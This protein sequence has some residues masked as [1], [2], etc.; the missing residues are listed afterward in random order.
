MTRLDDAKK[1]DRE[2]ETERGIEHML[3]SQKAIKLRTPMKSEVA[4]R[5]HQ[6]HYLSVM[7]NLPHTLKAFRNV[8]AEWNL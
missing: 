6:S 1:C 2:T 4:N 8:V 3:S 7:L 5:S